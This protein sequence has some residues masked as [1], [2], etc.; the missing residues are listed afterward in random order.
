MVSPLVLGLNL[1]G[2]MFTLY[3]KNLFFQ[4]STFGELPAMDFN[5]EEL[6]TGGVISALILLVGHYFPWHK[7]LG[8][9]LNRLWSYRY[10]SAAC[11]TG[12]SY[13]R[14]IGAGDWITPTGLMT[15]YIVAGTVVWAAYWLDT[16]GQNQTIKRRQ[17]DEY[18]TTN[19]GRQ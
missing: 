16:T 10:G 14:F 6:I 19:K 12:F 1:C 11:W 13:W 18:P 8:E 4:C 7:M 5:L 17:S 3:H 15:I 2:F 9:P